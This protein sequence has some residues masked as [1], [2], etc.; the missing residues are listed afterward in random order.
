[1]KFEWN[2]QIITVTVLRPPDQSASLDVDV[3]AD[4]IPIAIELDSGL[5]QRIE[6][7]API[8]CV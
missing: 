2:A 1:M 4:H 5:V 3:Q 7:L 8:S 6:K